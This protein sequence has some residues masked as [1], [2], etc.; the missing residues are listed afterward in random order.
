MREDGWIN[1]SEKTRVGS[2]ALRLLSFEDNLGLSAYQS[3]ILAG[4]KW[5]GESKV[6]AAAHL[7]ALRDPSK[8]D[9]E[10]WQ[11]EFGCTA[12]RQNEARENYA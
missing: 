6:L 11:A 12:R 5:A 4:G 2:F 9:L 1:A 10:R 8:F 3:N 7:A